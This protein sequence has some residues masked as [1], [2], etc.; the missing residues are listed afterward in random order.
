[1]QGVYLYVSFNKKAEVLYVYTDQETYITNMNAEI[2]PTKQQKKAF[3][4]M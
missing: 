3:T 1:M 2:S 4:L